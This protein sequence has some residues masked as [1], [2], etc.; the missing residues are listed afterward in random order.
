MKEQAEFLRFI[1]HKQENP[2]DVQAGMDWIC[3]KWID[4]LLL[5]QGPRPEDLP[6]P[7]RKPE[8]AWVERVFILKDESG[9]PNGRVE[10]G[11]L[12]LTAEVYPDWEHEQTSANEFIASFEELQA[13]RA[14]RVRKSIDMHPDNWYSAMENKA[15]WRPWGWDEWE[16][17]RRKRVETWAW[18]TDDKPSTR[19]EKRNREDWTWSK[20]YDEGGRRNEREWNEEQCG[21]GIARKGAKQAWEEGRDSR[22]GRW[23]TAG[24]R[25]QK[26]EPARSSGRKGEGRDSRAWEQSGQSEHGKPGA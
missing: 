5:L 7:R 14:S 10:M 4:D 20:A 2:G 25:E 1:L 15:E 24:K 11:L 21:K 22:T 23:A 18:A 16:A 9:E 12:H 13:L 26:G 8:L 6:F 19:S 3:K 17:E